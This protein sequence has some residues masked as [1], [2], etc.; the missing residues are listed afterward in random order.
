M[1]NFE[2]FKVGD[3]W[4]GKEGAEY[5]ILELNPATR[6]A[7][8]KIGTRGYWCTTEHRL[9]EWGYRLSNLGLTHKKLDTSKPVRVVNELESTYTV[10][11]KATNGDV[12]L[13]DKQGYLRHVAE[14]LLENVSDE[15][16]VVDA[17]IRIQDISI[18]TYCT[19]KGGGWAPIIENGIRIDHLPTGVSVRC[20]EWRSAHAN[21]ALAMKRLHFILDALMQTSA[22]L[23]DETAIDSLRAQTKETC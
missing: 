16:I 2:E 7:L 11:G 17:T 22:D 1:P 8:V 10:V 14:N 9:V 19:R 5:E 21:R 15:S 20:D 18:Q 23:W 6:E 4:I 12:I 13:E 3:V